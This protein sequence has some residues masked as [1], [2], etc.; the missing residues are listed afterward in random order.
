MEVTRKL[1]QQRGIGDGHG[2]VYVS[3][4]RRIPVTVWL[5]LKTCH[6]KINRTSKLVVNVS[7]FTSAKNESTSA[8][9]RDSPS[10]SD[11]PFR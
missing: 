4:S 1:E 10:P 7:S 3:Q 11:S 8:R 6:M 5:E 2:L 9:E